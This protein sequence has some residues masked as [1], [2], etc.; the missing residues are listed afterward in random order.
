M[1]LSLDSSPVS[2]NDTAVQTPLERVVG[3][4]NAPDRGVRIARRDTTLQS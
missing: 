2:P 1:P 4:L 3:V